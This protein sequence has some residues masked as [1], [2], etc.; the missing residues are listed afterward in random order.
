MLNA[1]K[2]VLNHK[3]SNILESVLRHYYLPLYNRRITKLERQYNDLINEPYKA[4]KLSEIISKLGK[5]WNEK[6]KYEDCEIEDRV[7]G[8]KSLWQVQEE[9][10]EIVKDAR[11]KITSAKTRNKKH[12]VFTEGLKKM[13]AVLD[14]WE[15]K[16]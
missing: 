11:Y 14:E 10:Y 16:V 15:I 1:V 13:A 8:A 7:N 6:L 9:V 2:R 4:G 12:Q 5:L 3:P